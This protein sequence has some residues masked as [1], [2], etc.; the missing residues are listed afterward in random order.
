MRTR[1][2][3][4]F[5]PSSLHVEAGAAHRPWQHS[6]MPEFGRH[7]ALPVDL[8]LTPTVA[9]ERHVV[10]IGRDDRLPTKA[11]TKDRLN[12]FARFLGHRPSAR[13]CEA[14]CPGGVAEIL[15]PWSLVASERGVRRQ[16]LRPS[17]MW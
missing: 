14:S 5:V 6:S 1:A 13:I 4:P 16:R 11:G 12:D 9:F 17:P 7:R 2:Q 8:E 3:R 15:C 10:V